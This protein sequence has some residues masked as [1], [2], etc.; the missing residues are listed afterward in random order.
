M[1]GKKQVVFANKFVL[2][3]ML[4]VRDQEYCIDIAAGV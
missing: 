3:A 4:P 1:F 2:T